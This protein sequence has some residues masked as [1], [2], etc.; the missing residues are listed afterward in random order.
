MTTSI[1]GAESES[2]LTEIERLAL[3]QE[4]DQR[5]RDLQINLD[6]LESD[7]R[8]R[9]DDLAARQEKVRSLRETRDQLEAQKRD[10]E[11]QLETENTSMKDRRMRLNRVRSEKELQAVRREIEL[12]KEAN[13]K[14]ETELLAAMELYEATLRDLAV[15]EAALA[16]V[17]GPASSEIAEKRTRQTELQRNAERDRGARETLAAQLNRSLRSKYEQIFSRRGGVAVVEVRAGTCQGCHMHVPPQLY[18][19]I[20][21]HREVVRQCPNCHRMLFWR[22]APDEPGA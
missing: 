9:A 11:L 15:A 22:P 18:N 17:E 3:L 7:I 12:G 6:A 14:Y 19:E 4:V 21:K 20:Q 16:E 13:Q 10:L 2:S 1:S 8:L 5:L